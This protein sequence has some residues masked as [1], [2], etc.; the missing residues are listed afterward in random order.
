VEKNSHSKRELATFCCLARL[1]SKQYFLVRRHSK[2]RCHR[3]RY[4]PALIPHRD[5]N[6]SCALRQLV[7]GQ[8]SALCSP[9]YLL[10][11]LHAEF[12]YAVD[13]CLRCRQPTLHREGG[14]FYAPRFPPC[15]PRVPIGAGPCG[16]HRKFCAH[17]AALRNPAILQSRR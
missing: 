14:V 5:R 13:T 9:I 7:S 2:L 10:G 17:S 6:F 12:A 16:R 3:P 1:R 15:T 11:S 4:V 8:C